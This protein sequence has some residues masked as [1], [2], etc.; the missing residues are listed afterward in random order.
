[1]NDWIGFIGA[2]L[3]AVIGGAASYFAT[4][5]QINAQQEA[6]SQ[7]LQER[8]DLAIDA[9]HAFLS[10]EISYNAKKVRYLKTY[11]DK[12]YQAFKTEGTIVNFTKELKFSEYD[13]AK[14][15]LLRTNSILVIRTIQL[16]QSFK[17][18]DRYKDEQLRDLNED[19]FNFLRSCAPEWEKISESSF[20]KSFVSKKINDAVNTISRQT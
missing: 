15:E 4:K 19:E 8:N 7:A 17:L 3:G 18:I 10:D 14:K 5:M 1:M 6:S 9:I 16:Y 13:V 11:L 12:G 2:L 20:T